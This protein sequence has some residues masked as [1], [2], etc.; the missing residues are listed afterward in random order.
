MSKRFNQQFIH[1]LKNSSMLVQKGLE[2]RIIKLEKQGDLPT[3]MI[4]L[5]GDRDGSPN[6]TTSQFSSHLLGTIG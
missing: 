5:Y 1:V 3:R 2:E 6:S 4:P